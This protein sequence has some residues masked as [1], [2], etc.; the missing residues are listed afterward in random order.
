MNNY[1]LLLI[2][3]KKEREGI[4]YFEAAVKLDRNYMEPKY[5]LLEILEK[6]NSYKLFNNYLIKEINNFPNDKIIKYFNGVYLNL[7]SKNEKAIEL[8]KSFKFTN[9][10]QDW[11]YKRLNLLGKIYDKIGKYSQAFKFHTFANEFLI[12]NNCL[13]LFNEKKYF[14]KLINFKKYINYKILNDT[15][16][17]NKVSLFFLVGFPRSGTTL[18]DSILSSNSKIEV[19][20]EKPLIETTIKNISEKQKIVCDNIN[21]KELREIYYEQISKII[22]KETQITRSCT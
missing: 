17:H 16:K 11:E 4:K 10:D 9:H 1:G 5:N 7:N 2:S 14:K 19:I 12:N 15:E 22:S 3:Q 13:K 21:K 20:E 8:L 18:L 6:S